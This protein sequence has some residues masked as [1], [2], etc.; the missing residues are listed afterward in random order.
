[1]DNFLNRFALV[2]G[3]WSAI[4]LVVLACSAHAQDTKGSATTPDGKTTVTVECSGVTSHCTVN[5]D[6]HPWGAGWDNERA[7]WVA[8]KGYAKV[9]KAQGI[10]FSRFA[11][12]DDS[13]AC[14]TA[15]MKAGRPA[16]K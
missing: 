13:N 10:K 9:C 8:F 5:E 12:L 1:M 16:T 3:L 4:L 15:W 6:Y 2:T 11:K 14:Y 7:E